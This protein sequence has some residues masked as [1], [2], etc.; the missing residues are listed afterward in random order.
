MSIVFFNVRKIRR[1]FY[2]LT[3]ELLFERT[4]GLPEYKVTETHVKRLEE[5]IGK[6]STGYGPTAG[7]NIKNRP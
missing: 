2:N 4:A 5:L 7:G 3:F 1:G 6:R